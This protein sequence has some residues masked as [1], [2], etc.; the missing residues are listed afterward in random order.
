MKVLL[1]NPPFT[2]YAGL[3]GHGGKALPLNLAYLA[4]YLKQQKPYMDIVIL[5]CEGLSLSY[6]QIEKELHRINPDIV[7]ITT[8][9]P[10]YA[11]VLEVARRIKKVDKSIKVVVGGPHPTALPEDTVKESDIDIAVLGEGEVTFFEIVNTIEKNNDIAD[12]L[13]IAYKDRFGKIHRN[14]Q[15][16]MI[17]D[18]DALPFPARELFPLEIYRPPPTK[19]I[20]NK[21]PGNMI[22]SRGCP[23]TCTYC[24]A[25]VIWRHRVRFRSVGN[26]VDEIEHCVRDFGIGEI[27]F[28][29]ELFT[30][31]KNRT[32]EICREI[33]RRKLDVVW[34]CMVRVDYISDE[35]LREMK[36]AGCRKI[37]FGFES[38]SQMILDKMKKKV[39]LDKAEQAVRSVKKAGIKTAGNFMFGNI[40]ETEATIRQSIELAKK[41]NT[42]TC[43]F[44][45]ASPYPG[46]E[47]YEI[48]KNE[49]YL[50]NDL[51]WKDFCLVSNNLPPL[52]LPGLPA[53]R[54][55]ELQKKA[56]REYYLRFRYVFEKLTGIR[57]IVE[58][59]NLLNGAL[60]F[61][62]IEKGS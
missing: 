37:M 50:R 15:R 35:V 47:F 27:N 40:G 54:L 29:D 52:N 7:G 55:L 57:S 26:V 45:I 41:L 9:T 22:T 8:S 33:R 25:T 44:F 13:G 46:T 11:Q 31:K 3:K 4:G 60:L 12:V 10:A 42:D 51:E 39:A 61:L 23:Y 43:A 59:K 28:H 48:A 1:L 5:D 2:E 24:M 53:V 34:V 18:L 58:I 30:L 38:G 6:N 49:G 62:R 36:L 19:R 56:Y 21:K 20:S 14:P 32:I 16:P 17:K